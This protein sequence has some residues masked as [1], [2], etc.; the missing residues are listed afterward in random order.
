MPVYVVSVKLISILPSSPKQITSAN[1]F[2]AKSKVFGSSTV[3]F[4]I[5]AQPVVVFLTSKVYKPGCKSKN[6]LEACGV[7]AGSSVNS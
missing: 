6:K 4:K 5:I 7:P 1:L 3:W 2:T